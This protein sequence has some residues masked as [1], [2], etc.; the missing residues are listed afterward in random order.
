MIKITVETFKG[1]NSRKTPQVFNFV[2][3]ITDVNMLPFA[4]KCES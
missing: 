2:V 4:F 1:L 3:F